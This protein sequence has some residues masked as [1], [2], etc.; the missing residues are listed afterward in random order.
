MILQDT[1]LEKDL[2]RLDGK[3]VDTLI[4]DPLLV[5]VDRRNKYVS[6]VL[7]DDRKRGSRRNEVVSTIFIADVQIFVLL[8]HVV[9]T[10]LTV[11]DF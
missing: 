8:G 6:F 2:Q 1:L 3:K 7:E 4:G 10:V 9:D 11:L 5:E